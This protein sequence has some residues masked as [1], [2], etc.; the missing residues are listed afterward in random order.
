MRRVVTHGVNSFNNVKLYKWGELCE[1]MD[2]PRPPISSIGTKALQ[3]IENLKKFAS[4]NGF[5]SL[6]ANQIYEKPR[7]FVCLRKPLLVPQQWTDY[8]KVKPDDYEAI[9]NPEL[10]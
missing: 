4:M 3:L 5:C 8:D 10:K 9:I 2:T 7:I 6:S 1:V